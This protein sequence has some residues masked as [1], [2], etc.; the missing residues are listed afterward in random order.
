MLRVVRFSIHRNKIGK[1]GFSFFPQ[2]AFLVCLRKY[3]RSDFKHVLGKNLTQSFYH[4][5]LL[6]TE[7]T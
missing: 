2:A 3:L 5:F 1:K 6:T 7:V 4:L